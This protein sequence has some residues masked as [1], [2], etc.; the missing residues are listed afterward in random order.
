MSVN[1][2]WNRKITPRSAS[3]FNDFANRFRL[4]GRL[5]M[6]SRVN[7]FLKVLPVATLIYVVFPVDLLSLNPVDDAF[8]VWAGTTL[9][10][11]LCPPHIVEEHMK[12]LNRAVSGLWKDFPGQAGQE[13]VVDGEYTEIRRS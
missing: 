5:V 1:Q 2:S 6:D 11:E 13:D 3:F 12:M 8:L 10:V 9:F 7:P 4:I